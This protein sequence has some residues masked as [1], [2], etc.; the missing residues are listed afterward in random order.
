MTRKSLALPDQQCSSN[1]A[2]Y[3]ELDKIHRKSVLIAVLDAPGMM[4]VAFGFFG[5]FSPY[6]RDVHP[7]L[8]N[9]EV[10]ISMIAA[11]SVWMLLCASGLL[12]LGSQRR[13]LQRQLTDVGGST[14]AL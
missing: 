7:L 5:R 11:G 9:P 12:M 6:S 13:R 4:L 3:E 1:Q 14:A 10:N 2:V 8:S